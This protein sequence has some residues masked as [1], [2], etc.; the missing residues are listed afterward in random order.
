MSMA[1]RVYLALGAFLVVVGVYLFFFGGLII[2]AIPIIGAGIVLLTIRSRENQKTTG[3]TR[4]SGVLVVGLLSLLS[5]FP[6]GLLALITLVLHFVGGAGLRIVITPLEW[7]PI[8]T[9]AFL[10]LFA[11]VT[12]IL[13]LVGTSSKYL[14]FAMIAFWVILLA[15]FACWDYTIWRSYGLDWIFR[16]GRLE[17]WN[18]TQI[19]VSLL[20]LA[21]G[22]GC[23]LYFQTAKVKQYFHVRKSSKT[24]DL[25]EKT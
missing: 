11:F 3:R 17:V 22:I 14:W 9:P 6:L 8:L 4:P 25:S 5:S 21:Y 12:S 10:G 15:F 18:Y 20:P 7:L 23:L 19:I 24:G 1:S 13:L 16:G 2:F